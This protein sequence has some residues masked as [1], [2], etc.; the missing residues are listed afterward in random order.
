MLQERAHVQGTG[1]IGGKEAGKQGGREG[2][3]GD[4]HAVVRNI[5]THSAIAQ[6]SRSLRSSPF[7]LVSGTSYGATEPP[8][9]ALL[10]QL[11]DHKNEEGLAMLDPTGAH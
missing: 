11:C 7:M 3:V 4:T 10:R 9:D 5:M 2:E 1:E 8:A 6:S